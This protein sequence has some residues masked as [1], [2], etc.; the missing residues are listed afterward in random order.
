MYIEFRPSPVFDLVQYFLKWVKFWFHRLNILIFL[1]YLPDFL[2]LINECSQTYTKRHNVW[3]YIINFTRANQGTQRKP[4]LCKA[5]LEAT[6]G[7]AKGNSRAPTHLTPSAWKTTQRCIADKQC[8]IGIFFGIL[9]NV[10]SEF[11]R[12]TNCMKSTHFVNMC[13]NSHYCMVRAY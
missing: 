13:K 2:W 4:T 5:H 1:E 12:H 3:W 10:R 6:E 11:L 8:R 7:C 9:N